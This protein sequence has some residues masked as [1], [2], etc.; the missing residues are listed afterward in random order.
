MCSYGGDTRWASL[1]AAMPFMSSGSGPIDG[2]EGV[3]ACTALA[4]AL[5]APAPV[6]CSRTGQACSLGV[7]EDEG[8]GSAWRNRPP[9]L[10]GCLHAEVET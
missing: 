10:V 6:S 1:M 7:S 3:A 5:E 4:D 9:S 2:L 8:A